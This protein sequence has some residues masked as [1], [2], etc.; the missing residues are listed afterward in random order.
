L[1]AGKEEVEGGKG[2]GGVS[3]LSELR[4]RLKGEAQVKMIEFILTRNYIHTKDALHTY[5]RNDL[6]CT[7][8][9]ICIK[10]CYNLTN[11]API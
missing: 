1:R 3:Q 5:N 6:S 10:I 7:Q 8:K 9:K 4:E 2:G 11:N